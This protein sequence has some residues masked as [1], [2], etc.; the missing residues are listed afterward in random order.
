MSS[1]KGLNL[2]MVT[3]KIA[4]LP[5]ERRGARQKF[6]CHAKYSSAS[7][8]PKSEP[9]LS[10]FASVERLFTVSS[11]GPTTRLKGVGI[12]KSARERLASITFNFST[13]TKSG[14]AGCFA[15]VPGALVENFWTRSEKL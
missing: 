1:Y 7:V 9:E 5:V 2:L 4:T 8:L 14:F 12:V 6:P 11:T 15:V 10:E 3:S 13:R